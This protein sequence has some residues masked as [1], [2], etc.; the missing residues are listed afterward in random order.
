[1]SDSSDPT[2]GPEVLPPND[3]ET[4]DGGTTSAR[5]DQI[6][7]AVLE[8]F[9]HEKAA[10][11]LG[12]STVTLWRQMQNPEFAAALREA[13]RQAVSL[14]IARLQNAAGAAVTTQL[15]IMT[16]REAPASVRLRASDMILQGAFRGTEIEDI[17]ARVA[18]LERSMEMSRQGGYR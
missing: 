12:I 5:Q 9:T 17:D 7:V 14:A 3:S 1:M 6:I 13:R 15:R 18:E 8:N 16:D 10:A 11:A 2:E 4:G